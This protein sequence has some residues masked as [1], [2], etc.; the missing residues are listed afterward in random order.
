VAA[1]IDTYGLLRGNERVLVA[2]SGGPDSV[3]LL[4]ALVA[5]RDRYGI[6][7]RVAHLNHGLRDAAEAE[8]T[9]VADL[10]DKLALPC[11]AERRD[12]RAYQRDHG[13]SLEDAARRVRYAFLAATAAALNCSK[14]AVGHQADDTAELVLMNLLRGSG[15]L[16]LAGIAPRQGRIIRP[17]IDIHRDRILTY[18]AST[19]LGYCRDESNTDPS[20]TRNRIR[21]ELIPHL[22]AAYNPRLRRTLQSTARI[23]RD[24]ETWI[25]DHIGHI[26]PIDARPSTPG[27]PGEAKIRIDRSALTALPTALQRRILRRELARA[28]AD[29]K[30]IEFAHIEAIRRLACG[31]QLDP[32]W[33]D[34]PRGLR[35][36][37]DEAHITLV[38]ETAA[39]RQARRRCAGRRQLP[40]ISGYAY[41]ISRPPEAPMTVE[42]PE[43]GARLVLRTAACKGQP[44]PMPS[45]ADQ[46]IFDL[47]RL[48]FPLKLRPVRP[49]DKM[50]PLGLKG[51][52][53]IGDLLIDCKIPSPMRRRLPVL[54]SDSR[55]VWLAGVRRD[56]DTRVRPGTRRLLIVEFCLL[57]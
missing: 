43:I 21:H 44:L 45:G 56:H 14:I 8:L 30:R 40:D 52:K 3:A 25:N 49:G 4:W 27:D 48:V 53:K 36:G 19:Q 12:V 9:F 11:H 7:L 31:G 15:L 57:K 26:W 29:L 23:F 32:K 22:E 17:L 42:L 51:H 24:E 6:T 39:E 34:L 1:A 10:A 20:F 37:M 35:V 38:K 41:E 55:I 28:A 54:I 18:L 16:G 50:R 47:D 5:L 13:L 2:V 46:A 33:L